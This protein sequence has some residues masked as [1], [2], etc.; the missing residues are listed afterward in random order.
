V[1]LLLDTHAFLWWSIDD[2]QLS[3]GAR[4]AITAAAHEVYVSAATAWEIAIQAALGRIDVPEDLDAFIA[5]EMRRSRFL[6]L[7][8]SIR[9]A[10][11]VRDLP[12]HHRD[13]FD[14]LL[15]AQALGE[16]L[17]LISGDPLVAAYPVSVLW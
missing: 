9:H 15:V 6:P 16:G 7:P 12:P 4:E 1:R 3:G 14:R 17:T 5:A 10:V 13:P 11:A 2:P 8:V